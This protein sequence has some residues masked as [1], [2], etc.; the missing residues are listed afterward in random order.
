MKNIFLEENNIFSE[1]DFK[2]PPTHYAPTYNW[3]WNGVLSHE[4]TDK[5][6]DEFERL[7]IKS[8]CMVVEPKEFRPS[9]M[10]SLLSPDYLTK[11]YFEEYKYTVQSAKE[12][13]MYVWFY[14]EG[15]WPSGGACGKVMIK[16]PEF[17]RRNLAKR[18]IILAKG[19][20]YNKKTDSLS[21][22]VD[23]I[24]IDDGFV[25]PNE[26]MV[27]EYY[28]QVR[29][30][31]RPSI[32]EVPDVTRKE[33]VDCF[34]EMTHEGY[35]T[36][37]EEYFGETLLTV[38]SDEPHG[39]TPV[40]FR[41]ELEKEFEEK[42]GYSIRKYLPYLL[43]KDDMPEDAAKAK[44][45][46]M[47]MCSKYFCNNYLLREKAWTNKHNM[48]FTGHFGGENSMYFG[49]GQSG[50][51]NLMRALRCFDIPGV[52]AIWRQIY[53]T[54]TIGKRD[55][56]IT[57]NNGFFP[58][59]A[60]SAAAQVG[61]RRAL[62]ESMGVYGAG[63]TFNDMRYVFN[64]QAVRGIN[65]FNVF[66]TFYSREGFHMT[67]EMPL[68]TEK[69]ACY[70]DLPAFNRFAERLSYLATLGER[71][72]DVG[73]Y[74][75]VNDCYVDGGWIE[76]DNPD[77][78]SKIYEEIGNRLEDENI[79]FDIIDD[80]VFEVSDKS[81]STGII[82]MGKGAY[83]TIVVPPCRYMPGNS[84][85]TLEKFISGGG[86][87]F[88]INGKNTPDIKG[89]TYVDSVKGII[90]D[91]LSLS[92]DTEK[93]RLGVR[94]TENGKLYLLF[95]E[96]NEVKSFRIDTS[97]KLTRLYAETGE[98]T[99]P[100]NYEVALQVGEMAFFFNGE[101]KAKQQRV[102]KNVVE[103]DNE[104]SFRKS[105]Q[106][107]I[108]D[109]NFISKDIQEEEQVVEL[110]D[111][112]NI[113]GKE[114]SGSGI[115]RTL[116]KKPENSGTL[117]LDLGKV[118]YSCEVFVN[119]KSLGIL[120]MSP[121]RCEIPESIVQEDNVLEIRVSNTPAN[122]Y[123]STTSFDKWQIWQLTTYHNTQK[124]Y[125]ADSIS[126]GLIGPVKLYY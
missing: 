119:G 112:V 21:A 95:N 66:G 45:L 44:Y 46:W 49:M 65:V 118:H 103:F 41:Q 72:A 42:N 96:S 115:Y 87:V 37:L 113:V 101:L 17:A 77:N 12:R 19:E 58:R 109:M 93:I 22:Y 75:P 108:G 36:Y 20:V 67:G 43:S 122:E 35:K 50:Y 61:S 88:I 52:D 106:F 99:I 48:L 83:K 117:L 124:L 126:G 27:Y 63:S 25:A 6:L 92:G 104:F 56:D 47:N 57:F 90:A 39:P 7:G 100:E 53:P 86:N 84:V 79:L 82:S 29:L 4:E 9:S 62:T 116:F 24:E 64:Y 23:N 81:A 16:H 98:I 85:Q 68:F 59:Y 14:D 33:A 31:E 51:Y 10:P 78:I 55:Y 13:G 105:N 54:F 91:T 76:D 34:I 107:L 71:V 28:E 110:G 69:H 15:G 94:E 8:I 3:V 114:F 38:F 102:Y 125:H 18:E 111:W 5:Q 2:N 73:Y 40:P 32:P 120:P 60:S 74:M 26:L 89:A 1:N 11:P 80:D 30:F 121:Y 123:E 97:E 70:K